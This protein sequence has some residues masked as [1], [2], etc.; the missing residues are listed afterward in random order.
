[1]PRTLLLP[2]RYCAPIGYY[3]ALVWADVA[4]YDTAAR[5]DKRCKAVHRADI[6]DTHGPLQLTVPVSKGDAAPGTRP[7]WA[8]RS[9]SEHGRWWEIHRIA[10]ESAYGRTPYFQFYIDNLLPMLNRSSVGMSIVDFDR[11]IDA[12]IRKM[13]HI[14]TPVKPCTEPAADAI[15]LSRLVIPPAPPYWQVRGEKHGFLGGLSILDLLFN[16]GPEAQLVLR[17]MARQITLTQ[18]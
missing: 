11:A 2:P 12:S 9:V 18:E 15:T 6:A 14:A 10:L 5:Y 3:A 8:Q 7:L 13:L 4:I 1:M 17:D 16:L